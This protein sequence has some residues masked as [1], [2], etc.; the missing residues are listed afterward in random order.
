MAS[1]PSSTIFT[2]LKCLRPV[3]TCGGEQ[4][5]SAAPPCFSLACFPFSLMPP[6]GGTYLL[7]KSGVQHN[8]TVKVGERVTWVWDDDEPHT[9]KGERERGPPLLSE[10]RRP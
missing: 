3:S 10:M 6:S 9:V 2:R 5:R 7:W 8:T 4:A 1:T